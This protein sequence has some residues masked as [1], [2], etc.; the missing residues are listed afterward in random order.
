MKTYQEL[1]KEYQANQDALV[2]K[3]FIFFAFS[4]SQFEEGKAKIGITDNKD[5]CSIGAGGYMPKKEADAYFKESSRLYKE[6]RA[7]IKANKEAKE[8]AI[9]YELNNHE[10]FYTGRLDEVIEKFN[11]VYTVDDIKAV[12]KKHYQYANL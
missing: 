4:N 1:K 9:L 10:A 8:G 11:G 3:Y 7:N 12:Y 6:F 2:N 5:L